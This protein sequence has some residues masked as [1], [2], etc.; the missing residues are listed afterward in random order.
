LNRNSLKTLQHTAG[1]ERS[2]GISIP[3]DALSSY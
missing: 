3:F 2:S 1:N